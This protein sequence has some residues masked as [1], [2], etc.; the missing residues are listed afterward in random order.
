MTILRS[1]ALGGVAQVPEGSQLLCYLVR[2]SAERRTWMAG[3]YRPTSRRWK[4]Q[5]PIVMPMPMTA[6]RIQ[7]P[8]Q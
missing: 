7:N 5:S 1:F 2:Y 4:L 3:P 6:T 8:I